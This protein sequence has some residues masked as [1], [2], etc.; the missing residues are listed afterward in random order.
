M[1][2][3]IIIIVFL[4][5]SYASAQVIPIER[6][7]NWS[8]A[9]LSYQ[10][11][12]PYAELNVKDYGATGNGTT[13]DQP[14]IM[15]AISALGGN[16]GYVYF[17]PGNYLMTAPVPL[18]DS[19]ILKG[20][21][22]DSSVLLFNFGTASL[23][24]ITLSGNYL[25]GFIQIDGGYNKGNNRITSDSA[26]VFNPL[27]YA[28][29]VENN[30]AWNDVPIDWAEQSVGQI[31]QIDH[32]IADTIFLFSPLRITYDSQLN[33]RIRKISP[34]V[35]AGVE[36]LK[37]KR[38]DQSSAGANI[39]ISLAANCL[40]R[41]VESDTSV[42]AH[43]D[44]FQSTRVLV[45]GNYF[46]HAFLYDGASKHGYG[47]TLNAHSGEC[48][49][50]NNI[51]RY[52]RHA[53]MVKTGANGN[54]FSYNYSREVH[55]SEFLSNYGGDISLHG[56]YAYA[57]LFEGNIVQNI[58]I[59]HEWGPSGPY[60][61]FFRNRAE[62]YGIIFSAGK[63]STSNSEHI[64]GNDVTYNGIFLGPYTITGTGHIE[65][66]NNIDGTIRPPGTNTLTDTSYYLT[67]E[68]VFWDVA[69]SWPSLGIPNTLDTGTIPAKARWD[70]R[71]E[72]TVCPLRKEWT[73]LLSSNWNN[74]HNW[75]PYGIP[76][77]GVEVTIPSSVP[78]EPQISTGMIYYIRSLL[79]KPNTGI[80]L[81]D[82]SWLVVVK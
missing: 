72:L 70:Q 49:I 56:H 61:T 66:G 69:D 20:Y 39:M 80:Q 11:A 37:I 30:G 3:V 51:F 71:T 1:K 41:G 36:C 77:Q 13:N 14:A 46:H 24:C 23:D 67:E 55:R 40:V 82:G 28:E 65:Y 18:P 63:P 38:L 21:S 26:F 5:V 81:S 15:S 10:I 33:P 53:M 8:D 44:I 54:V 7:A 59:D 48:L 9:L 43:I 4:I 58:Q 31:V 27:D 79:I 76:D 75:Y 60:N 73:G 42:S 68:P 57:N 52:L 78:N 12:T 17:P 2:P 47:V 19:V 34:R 45:E 32:V 74:P 25:S 50:T 6:Q 62:N 16:L 29:I 35:N 64:V 22:S